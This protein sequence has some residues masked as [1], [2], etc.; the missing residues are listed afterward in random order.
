VGRSAS[1]RKPGVVSIWI[2]VAKPD[3]KATRGVDIL[4]GMC[5]V[6]SYDADDQEVILVPA[7]S[8]S[9]KLVADIVGQFS[10]AESF[11]PAVAAAASERGIDRVYWA[12]AQF[13]FAYHPERVRG[14][15]WSEPVFL[16]M[17]PWRDDEE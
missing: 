15:V 16:G 11:L 7:R 3:L 5:G 8:R 14:E 9:P 12:V 13:D 2:G 1:Y 10:Y 17:F 6:D 4:K